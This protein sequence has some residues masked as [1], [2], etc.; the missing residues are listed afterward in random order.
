[1]LVATC[2]FSH[3]SNILQTQLFFSTYA[4]EEEKPERKCSDVKSLNL[5]YLLFFHDSID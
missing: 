1:M 5:K 4:A 2:V 3:N